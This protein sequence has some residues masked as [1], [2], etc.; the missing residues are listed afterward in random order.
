MFFLD[1]VYARR[2]PKPGLEWHQAQET[3][4]RP[5]S[6]HRDVPQADVQHSRDV[7]TSSSE[8]WD[9]STHGK[10]SSLFSLRPKSTVTTASNDGSARSH[11]RSGTAGSTHSRRSSLAAERPT[12]P[13]ETHDGSKSRLLFGRG[14]NKESGS[15]IRSPSPIDADD[16]SDPKRKDR[17]RE[18]HTRNTSSSCKSRTGQRY[19]SLTDSIKPLRATAFQL[20]LDFSTS[21]GSKRSK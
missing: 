1:E 12:S 19:D 17:S 2:A 11:S 9:R 4:R 13:P 21:R 16:E 20:H 18:K 5:R 3:Q 8:I 10:R 14:R 15:R 6:P 7:S